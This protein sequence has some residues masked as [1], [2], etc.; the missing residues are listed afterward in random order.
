MKDYTLEKQLDVLL[1][2]LNAISIGILITDCNQEDDPIVYANQGFLDMTGYPIDEV[3]GRNCRFLQ[4]PKTNPESIK[5]I[6]SALH[7]REAVKVEMLNY[8]KDGSTFWN[9][10]S[11]YPVKNSQGNVTHCIALERSIEEPK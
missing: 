4:G 6:S 8:R 3:L 5:K 9:H 7:K 1:N 2:A 10:F 11:I